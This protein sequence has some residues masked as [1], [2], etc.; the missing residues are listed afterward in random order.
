[1]CTTEPS[2]FTVVDLP[3]AYWALMLRETPA[4]FAR[5]PAARLCVIGGERV[6]PPTVGRWRTATGA[7]V[8]LLDTYGPTEATVVAT[9]ADLGADG[10]P[11]RIGRPVGPAGVEVLGESLVAV[12]PGVVGELALGGA[13]IAR[14]YHGQAAATADRFRPAPGGPRR[15]L[16]GDAGRLHADGELSFEG[17]LDRQLKV[18]GQRVEPAEVESVLAAAPGVDAAA[19]W[20]E[21]A[22]EGLHLVAVVSGP[23]VDPSAVR[24]FL[25]TRLPDAALPSRLGVATSLPLTP[26]GKVDRELARAPLATTGTEPGEVASTPATHTERALA[27]TWAHLL[28][29]PAGTIGRDSSFFDLGGH[30]LLAMMLATRVERTF[31]IELGLRAVFEHPVLRDLAEEIDSAAPTAGPARP[32]VTRQPLCPSGL[33]PASSVQRQLWLLDQVDGG[34]ARWNVPAAVRATGPLDVTALRKAVAAVIERH[35]ILRTTLEEHDGIVYQRVHA[36]LEVA[37]PIAEIGSDAELSALAAELTAQPFDLA[38]GPP[39]R[40]IVVRR[41]GM[42]DVVLLCMHHT[43]VDGW[44]VG[45]LLSDLAAWYD[46]VKSGDPPVLPPLPV[47][48]T[49]FAEWQ[50]SWARTDL[51]REHLDWWR[52]YLVGAPAVLDVAP[53]RPRTAPPDRAGVSRRVAFGGEVVATVGRTA[54]ELGVT[55]NA[56]L[57]AAWAALI[58]RRTGRTD[59]VIGTPASGR[60]DPATDRLIGAF[61]NSLPVRIDL[62]RAATFADLA[63]H[64]QQQLLDVLARQDVPF[65]A[66]VQ[67][68]A[69]P[70]TPLHDPLF[71]VMFTYLNEPTRSELHADDLYFEPLDLVRGQANRDLTLRLVDEDLT[72]H[73]EAAADRFDAGDLAEWADGLQ[74]LVA[75][76]AGSPRTPL[77]ELP[78]TAAPPAPLPGGSSG[79]S[80]RSRF[81]AAARPVVAGTLA[82]A[83]GDFP[84]RYV[85]RTRDID[86]PAWARAHRDE[87]LRDLAAHGATLFR[88]FGVTEPDQLAAV[89]EAVSGALTGYSEAS[90]PRTHIGERIYTSTEY[91]AD[92]SI[93]LHNEMAYAHSWPRHVWFACRVAADE[94][95]ATPIARCTSVLKALAPDVVDEFRRRG[96]RYLRTYSPRLDLPWQQV[97]A[98]ADRDE[99]MRRCAEWGLDCIWPSEDELRTI[100]RRCAA[101]VTLPGSGQEAWFNS[102]HMFH[103]AAL[104][105]DVATALRS[106]AA[107]DE[108]PRH[109]QFGDGG[110]IPDETIAHVRDTYA[111]LAVR[112]GWR[113][114]DALLINNLAVAHGRD[115]YAGA[116]EIIVAMAG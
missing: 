9:C 26:N 23:D 40:I 6:S 86:A 53:A 73:L 10:S 62:S 32:P 20:G 91:P 34:A 80:A 78:V 25:R 11:P 102:A 105:A 44:S 51:Y 59:L 84:R 81:A 4:P 17:R 14:G 99:V 47:Q 60:A 111:K 114:G 19:V 112:F 87:I 46:A 58:S 31:G 98:T 115:P 63:D 77:A 93:M 68:V 39:F 109:A 113:R 74:S 13:G 35:E 54:R 12:P 56:V 27:E 107:D 72:G 48:Y 33:A 43:C 21:D 76:A 67:A 61:M 116:R 30:S 92:Q 24:R 36:T 96:V 85:C 16:T 100:S 45:V 8:R 88:G 65:D 83:D 22:P 29:A 49:D 64:V 41:P 70:R 69:P 106:M 55:V 97:F 101:T 79:A 82:E 5:A 7:Q 90:T 50:R 18:R 110:T 3:T 89:A 2:L 1:M 37:V 15:Y 94:G 71:Q 66:I 75:A 104:P 38:L 108:L 95:G 52:T 28:R 42:H 57:L 103:V